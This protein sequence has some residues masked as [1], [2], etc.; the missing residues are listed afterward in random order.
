MCVHVTP[1][2]WSLIRAGAQALLLGLITLGTASA[3]PPAPQLYGF[4]RVT[5]DG[6]RIPCFAKKTAV[7]MTAPKGTLLEVLYVEGDRY[8]RKDAN[9]YWI[10]LPPDRWGRRV[11]G[12]IR[13]SAIEHVPLPP[14]T[15]LTASV[16]DAPRPP[17][18]HDTPPRAPVPVEKVAP[19]ARPVIAD[20]VLNF[21]FGKSA[22]TDEARRKLDGAMLTP[23]PNTQ[24][25]TIELE[26]HADWVG[27]QA[28]NDRL[29]L[30]RAQTVKRYLTEHFGV[31][32]EGISVVSYGE[33][34]PIA[35]NTTRDGRARNRRVVIKGGG[36]PS[37]H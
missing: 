19:A 6:T 16:A 11:T 1:R 20:V 14:P 23:A 33:R 37:T 28:Y 13:G 21:E 3:Q 4:V 29:G 27:T 17:D 35:P 12:W 9:R 31:P 8:N 2:G 24:G 36:S 34:D 22:L 7:C 30:A 15:A 18:T 10:M 25:L 32:A 5:H 26:G